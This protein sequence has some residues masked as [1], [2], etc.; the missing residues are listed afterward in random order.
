[1]KVLQPE[2]AVLVGCP[3]GIPNCNPLPVVKQDG[4]FTSFWQPDP[5]DLAVLNAGGS[6]MLTFPGAHPVLRWP[7]VTEYPAILA[8]WPEDEQLSV[9]ARLAADEGEPG[10]GSPR[11]K[12]GF[13]AGARWQKYRHVTEDKDP[14]DVEVH[15]A[16]EATVGGIGNTIAAF[17]IGVRWQRWRSFTDA[18]I[19]IGA[20]AIVQDA[21]SKRGVQ[22]TK[23]GFERYKK[24]H[25]EAYRAVFETL[26]IALNEIQMERMRP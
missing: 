26:R 3:D 12:D 6:I 1:M 4:E 14:E 15:K 23:H 17:K 21:M 7:A 11:F 13:K 20:F 8:T 16:A 2:D 9:A 10:S 18:E 19:E 5:E 24:D 25:A 22:L